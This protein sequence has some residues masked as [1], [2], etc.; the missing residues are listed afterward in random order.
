MSEILTYAGYTLALFIG[1]V[2]LTYVHYVAIMHFARFRDTLT[3]V[4]VIWGYSLYFVGF[5]L[6]FALNIVVMTVMF[7][8]LPRQVLVTSRLSC[9]IYDKGWR[10]K[11]AKWI[12]T[13]WLDGFDP[14]GPHCRSCDGKEHN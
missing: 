2:Y 7:L 5:L 3:K 12:C 14:K 6:D 4:Q 13:Q 10:G 8:Q 1:L 11:V 9:L